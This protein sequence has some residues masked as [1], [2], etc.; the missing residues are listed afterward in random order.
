MTVEIMWN[1]RR[2]KRIENV[3]VEELSSAWVTSVRNR[4]VFGYYKAMVEGLGRVIVHSADLRVITIGTK[5]RIAF[6]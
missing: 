2:V 3:P 6:K 1:G 4:T 5:Q